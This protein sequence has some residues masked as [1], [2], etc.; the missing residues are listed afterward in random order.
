MSRET[1]KGS[2]KRS[3]L[4]SISFV[5]L[6][7]VIISLATHFGML[8]VQNLFT[9]KYG[10][11]HIITIGIVSVSVSIIQLAILKS[12]PDKLKLLFERK[13]EEYR[14]LCDSVKNECEG[15][16]YGLNSV[17]LEKDTKLNVALSVF[18]NIGDE[19][20]NV[21]QFMEIMR[22]HLSSVNASTEEGIVGIIQTL[23]DIRNTSSQ[24]LD[25][26]KKNKDMAFVFSE[27]NK[28]HLEYNTHV[29]KSIENFMEERSRQIVADS[30]NVENVI[31]E[32]QKLSSFTS[33]IKDIA[34]QTNLMALNASVVAARA[35]DAGHGFRV[36]AK[37]I[38]ELSKQIA[39]ST[40]EIDKQF[41]YIIG[42]VEEKISAIVAES[43]T[44]VEKG[45]MKEITEGLL[46]MGTNF[47]RIDSFLMDITSHSQKTME[48]IYRN[49]IS[50]LGKI[51]FQDVTKQ[52]IEQV[53]G[54][55]QDFENYCAGVKKGIQNIH[56]FKLDSLQGLIDK[57]RDAYVTGQQR[58]T[59]DI[60]SEGK[61]THEEIPSIELF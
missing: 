35:G 28:E 6:S 18:D 21:F 27:K 59:H 15:K 31:E 56:T 17:N 3:K 20:E 7:A 51:Q 36:I 40:I 54:S 23:E 53:I 11:L 4:F 46:K 50:A 8:L 5:L 38:M 10:I 41:S 19:I 37:G 30:R 16:I 26:L 24:L 42:Y 60:I 39:E 32:I 47:E 61:E 14:L 1:S 22:G 49:I 13:N 2:T 34:G 43:R 55:L 33:F 48:E 57:T 45:Q 25:K 9:D 44:D 58:I 29:I 52:Q 12:I